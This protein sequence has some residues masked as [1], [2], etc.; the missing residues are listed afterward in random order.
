MLLAAWLPTLPSFD[1]NAA[2]IVGAIVAIGAVVVIAVAIA[3]PVVAI[4]G[5]ATLLGTAITVAGIGILTGS[6]AGG[7]AGFYWGRAGD[8]KRAEVVEQIMKVSNQLDIYFEPLSGN[9]NIAQDQVCTIVT[10]EEKGLDTKA[11]DVQIH[12]DVIRNPNIDDFFADV[13]GKIQGWVK[14][15]KAS[16]GDQER[17]RVQIFMKPF[18]GD[19]VY[20]K[21][22]NFCTKQGCVVSKFPGTWV[23]AL[24]R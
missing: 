18:P 22:A 19:G 7:A 20:D 24:D 15:H 2:L 4:Q 9:P 8:L 14:Q 10:Y 16:R 3:T 21:L 5:G 6:L 17:L 11:P 1:W 23:S 12:K 13:E